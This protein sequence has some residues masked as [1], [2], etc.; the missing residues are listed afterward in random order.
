MEVAM[1]A[2]FAIEFSK[3]E[4]MQIMAR[5]SSRD[6]IYMCWCLGYACGQND[7]LKSVEKIWSE[8]K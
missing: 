1:E 8:Q 3:N 7:A 2:A 5:M 6:I 4:A